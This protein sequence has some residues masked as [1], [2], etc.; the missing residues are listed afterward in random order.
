ME[1]L[2]SAHFQDA[3]EAFGREQALMVIL[4]NPEMFRAVI[5]RITVFYLKAN[6]LFY[7]STKGMLDAVL[8]GN[9]FSGSF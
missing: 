9:D 4:F 8:I 6:E 5:E 7:E 2:W 3:C 1:I